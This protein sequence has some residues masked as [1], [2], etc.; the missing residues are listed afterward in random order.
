MKGNHQG[1]EQMYT[2]DT[3]IEQR[4]VDNPNPKLDKQHSDALSMSQSQSEDDTNINHGPN[5]GILSKLRPKKFMND[6]DGEGYIASNSDNNLT[7]RECDRIR[8]DKKKQVG[9]H[10]ESSVSEKAIN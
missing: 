7:S 6:E 4:I 5:K 2:N 9:K 3:A 10:S 8:K 1:D